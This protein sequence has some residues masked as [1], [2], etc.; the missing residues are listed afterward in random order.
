MNLRGKRKVVNLLA[1]VMLMSFLCGNTAMARYV[2]DWQC[3]Y[4]VDLK[5]GDYIASVAIA[6]WNGDGEKYFDYDFYINEIPYF[7][8]DGYLNLNGAYFQVQSVVIND[9]AKTVNI[10]ADWLISIGVFGGDSGWM[11]AG[12]TTTSFMDERGWEDIKSKNGKFNNWYVAWEKTDGT[13]G[14]YTLEESAS[15]LGVTTDVLKNPESVITLTVLSSWEK[16]QYWYVGIGYSFSHSS[17]SGNVPSNPV[18]EN[19]GSADSA[20]SSEQT[21]QAEEPKN[22]VRLSNGTTL[23]SAGSIH[24]VAKGINGAAVV[25]PQENMDAEA[26]ISA[27]NAAAGT[28]AKLYVGNTYKGSEKTMLL[29]AV[30]GLNATI[31]NMIN[32]DL[33]TIDKTGKVSNL[34]NLAGENPEPVRMVIGL[35]EH[36]CK[37]G[38]SFSLVY[39]IDGQAVEITDMDSDN[40]TLTVDLTHFGPFAIIYR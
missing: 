6:K 15:I 19:G 38:R 4:M 17:V 23:T 31:V 7:I 20:G 39:Y 29:N 16:E 21:T 34:R 10:T 28:H 18:P 25:T 12:E 11:K 1:A 37:E 2:G 33:Y 27:E 14:S 13:Q 40:R 35:P 30:S 24:N 22:N 5:A 36:V 3:P 26:G 9:E 32:I 8:S